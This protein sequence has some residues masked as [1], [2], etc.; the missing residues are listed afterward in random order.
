MQSRLQSIEQSLAISD[1]SAGAHANHHYAGH[2]A[3]HTDEN[4]EG[5]PREL[6]EAMVDPDP[7][8]RRFALTSIGE[9]AGEDITLLILDALNDP[10]PS[11]RCA[12]AAATAKAN[13]SSAVF[14]LILLLADSAPEVV[15]EAMAAIE[16]ITGR[17]VDFDPK[18]PAKTRQKKIEK[19]KNWWKK[20]RFSRLSRDVKTA[21]R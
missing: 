5:V 13:I 14:S 15:Q 4:T 11:V 7:G 16:R 18:A 6:L 8:V 2:G 17:K 20:E 9:H 19:L 1:R 12:A 21:T 10:E 3:L